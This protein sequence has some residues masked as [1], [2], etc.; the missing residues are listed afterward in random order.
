MTVF[1]SV[2]GKIHAEIDRVVGSG[3]H[4]TVD[5]LED[6]P[7]LRAAVIE[8]YRWC[9]LISGG[10]YYL[11]DPSNG[12]ITL[13]FPFPFHTVQGFLTSPSRMISTMDILFRK[14]RRFYLTRGMC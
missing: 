7:Y 13:P 2:Q 9:P 11:T 10:N 3:R 1:P 6:M 12:T 8:N 5:D 4:P 14:A